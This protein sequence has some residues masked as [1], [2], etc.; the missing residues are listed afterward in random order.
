M[1]ESDGESQLSL[2]SSQVSSIISHPTPNYRKGLKRIRFVDFVVYSSK[3]CIN[4]I[5]SASSKNIPLRLEGKV[6]CGSSA[7]G[8]SD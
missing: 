5:V 7:R 1:V 2:F 3:V 4:I 8:I 6:V